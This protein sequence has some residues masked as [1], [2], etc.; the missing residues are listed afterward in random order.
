MGADDRTDPGGCALNFDRRSAPEVGP[1][2]GNFFTPMR[3]G[4][5]ELVRQIGAGGMGE[6]WVAHRR[7]P[8]SGRE[9][10]AIKRLPRRLAGDPIYRRTLLDEARL[11][12]LLEHPNI[13]RT[14][15][16]GEADGEVSSRW[17]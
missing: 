5:Y 8:G 12:S 7:G 10:V 6:V 1:R 13:I 15:E 16:A 2:S 9:P 3:L 14:L 4:S 11:S 17:S